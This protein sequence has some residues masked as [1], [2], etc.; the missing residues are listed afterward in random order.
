MTASN[1]SF[2]LLLSLSPAISFH[3]LN[4]IPRCTLNFMVWWFSVSCLTWHQPTICLTLCSYL[5]RF[6]RVL[7]PCH[8]REACWWAEKGNVGELLHTHSI[9][10]CPFI[11]VNYLQIALL[12]GKYVNGILRA[13][14]HM[15]TWSR[16]LHEE[17]KLKARNYQ[18]NFSLQYM[19]GVNV[20]A[21]WMFV[22]Y[23]VAL[24]FEALEL[25]CNIRYFHYMILQ[26]LNYQILEWIIEFP[27]SHSLCLFLYLPLTLSLLSNSTPLT[28]R[29][30]CPASLYSIFAFVMSKSNEML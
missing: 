15:Q 6:I 2:S 19:V 22:C 12:P 14:K 24:D 7:L 27:V 29:P 21:R 4:A 8:S 1:L 16:Q 13:N 20:V 5:L 30:L 3:M 25:T 18:L 11:C 28:R 9:R 10:F 17:R 23:I 26:I